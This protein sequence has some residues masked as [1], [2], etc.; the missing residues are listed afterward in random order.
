MGVGIYYIGY[1]TKKPKY[2]INNV[3][4]L[5]L[6]IGELDGYVEEKE[7]SKYLNI[8]LTDS[9]SI[10]KICKSLEWN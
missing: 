8:S 6:L 7:D 5:Y 2:N 9:N 4:P 3:N 10:K 1:A